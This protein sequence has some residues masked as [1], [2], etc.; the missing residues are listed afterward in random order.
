MIKTAIMADENVDEKHKSAA[1]TEGYTNDT[2]TDDAANNDEKLPSVSDEAMRKLLKPVPGEKDVLKIITTSYATTSDTAATARVIG[3]LD[4]YDDC[5]W[6]VEIAGK[7]FLLKI[8]NGVESLDFISVYEAAGKDYYKQGHAG[9]V[10]HFQS[11]IAETLNRH[12]IPTS[13]PVK[14]HNSDSPVSIH[15]LPVLSDAH[16]PTLLAVRLLTWVEGRPMSDIQLLP[17]EA[18]GDAGRTLGKI[19]AALD[20]TM[21]PTTLYHRV[22]TGPGYA[23]CAAAGTH[24]HLKDDSLMVPARRYHQWDGKNTAD[25]SKFVHCIADDNRRAMVESVIAA[26]NRELVGANNGNNDDSQ[27]FRKGIL[28]GD[29]NDANI[30]VD[31]DI[32]VCG[33]I[34]FGDSVER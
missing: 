7:P 34:D 11:A 31:P 9:S 3:Q 17:L 18:L 1:V 24:D 21:G 8:H 4:S 26:F 33:V 16:S 28:M 27:E 30:L 19:D 5:N 20:Q 14:P 23:S 10:I 12:H 13:V 29:F 32:H 22:E 25:L 2:N 15:A 6:K